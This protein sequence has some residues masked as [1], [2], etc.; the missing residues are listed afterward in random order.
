VFSC[1]NSTGWPEKE[2]PNSNQEKGLKPLIFKSGEID[3]LHIQ[4]LTKL[5]ILYSEQSL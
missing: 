5:S 3:F 4:N 1:G 2:Q